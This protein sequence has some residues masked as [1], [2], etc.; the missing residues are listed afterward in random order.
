[1]GAGTSLRLLPGRYGSLVV[2]D[3]ATLVLAG[4]RYD[5]TSLSIGAA[6]FVYV[7]S[8]AEVRVA[9]AVSIG[10]K[11]WVRPIDGVDGVGDGGLVISVGGVPGVVRASGAA[12]P[13]VAGPSV[14][15]GAGA[16][17][18]AYL[19]APTSAVRLGEGSVLVGAVIGRSVDVGDWVRLNPTSYLSLPIVE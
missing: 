8:A 1:M 4:G 6:A 12:S 2:G 7:E 19:A 18:H 13:A 10:P 14:E 11:S 9:G 5:L 15:I 3:G 17:V 16:I